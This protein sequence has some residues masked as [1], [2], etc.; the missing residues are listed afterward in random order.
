MI[1]L[2]AALCLVA[3]PAWATIDGWPA[4]HDVVGVAED[5]VLNVRAGPSADTEVIGT[6][7]HD[8]TGIEIIRPNDR[9]TWGLINL[10]ERP[11]WISLSYVQRH[12][13]QWYGSQIERAR[14]GGME[15][16]WSFEFAGGSAQWQHLDEVSTGTILDRF[17]AAGR[18]DEQGL[19]F[20][21]ENGEDGVAILRLGSCHDTMSDRE[22]G[23]SIHLVT[24]GAEGP[25]LYTGCC[26]LVP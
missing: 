9:H 17:P 1:R 26:N 5:D 21:F 15:P 4:L 7:A 11:G 24:G 20:R 14:C 16:F 22:Y 13:G 19:T 8:A 10:D 25:S 12:P 3:L 18:I 2:V 23:I 6:L